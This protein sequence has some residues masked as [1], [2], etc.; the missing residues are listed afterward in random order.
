MLIAIIMQTQIF[1]YSF[2]F[3]IYIQTILEMSVILAI[4]LD[5]VF[6]THVGVLYRMYNASA[7]HLS[8]HKRPWIRGSFQV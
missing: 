4:I 7:H 8:I 5:V 3:G 2:Q 6:K 1:I